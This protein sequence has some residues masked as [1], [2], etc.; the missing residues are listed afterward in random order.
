MDESATEAEEGVETKAGEATSVEAAVRSV[1]RRVG[2]KGRSY[3]RVGGARKRRKRRA[4]K[5]R[6]TT[7]ILP[8]CVQ[9]G[10]GEVEVVGSS[11]FVVEE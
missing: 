5:V 11:Y 9:R 10:G 1:S 7:L 2:L 4:S 3:E 6:L 8:V